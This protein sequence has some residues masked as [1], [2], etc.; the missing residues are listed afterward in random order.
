MSTAEAGQLFYLRGAEPGNEGRSLLSGKGTDMWG[1]ACVHWQATEGVT[2]PGQAMAG[3]AGISSCECMSAGAAG[4]GDGR[5][6]A[7]C[8]HRHAL[9][10]SVCLSQAAAASRVAGLLLKA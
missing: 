4:Q 7:E 6:A 10:R 5:C 2:M 1:L 3:A 8:C 9:R